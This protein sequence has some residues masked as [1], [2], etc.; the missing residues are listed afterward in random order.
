MAANLTEDY[1]VG[2]HAAAL[3]GGRFA[4]LAEV[5]GGGAVEQGG[6]S[7]SDGSAAAGAALVEPWLGGARGRWGGGEANAAPLGS[8]MRSIVTGII[9]G[10]SL[11]SSVT[12]ARKAVRMGVLG[13]IRA[14]DWRQRALGRARP[15]GPR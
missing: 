9:S 15:V 11:G 3:A 6:A 5:S 1:E 8:H 13:A 4:R 7:A 12:G 2:P 14:S 10:G